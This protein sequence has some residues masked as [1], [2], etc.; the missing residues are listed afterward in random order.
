L[1]DIF[2]VLISNGHSYHDILNTYSI[3]QVYAFYDSIT[4]QETRKKYDFLANLATTIGAAITLQISSTSKKAFK[5]AIKRW[6]KLIR[7][8][9]KQSIES[10]KKQ[11]PKKEEKAR[12]ILNQLLSLVPVVT[13]RGE[14]DGS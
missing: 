4:R 1:T 10:L 14:N 9:N 7:F 11:K 12:K 2:Q 13:E 5:E 6:D 8:F 3:S